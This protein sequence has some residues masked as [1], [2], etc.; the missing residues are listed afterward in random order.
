[1]KRKETP[2]QRN[3]RLWNLLEW[4]YCILIAIL[5]ALVIRMY[6]GTTVEVQQT[7]MIPTL[8]QGEKLIIDRRNKKEIYNYER[9]NLVI[10]EAPKEQTVYTTQIAPY[11][12][13][14]GIWE[15]FVHSV[16]EI[17]KTSYVKR[18]IALP[19]ETVSIQNNQVYINGQVLEE[20]Y[21][22]SNVITEGRTF[23]K[24]TVPE[25]CVFVMGDNR[26]GS[27]DSRDFGCI[28]AEKLEGK[29]WIRLLPFSKI[30][31]IE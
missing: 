14:K 26:Q 19:G 31:N 10:F 30:G 11:Q 21:I 12:E 2:M 13:K 8:E 23:H 5:L 18:L 6:V 17:Q 4:G 24:V 9:G 29:V 20:N 28:P 3:A 22:T 27:L 16:L 1:M 25:N 15:N 7:S